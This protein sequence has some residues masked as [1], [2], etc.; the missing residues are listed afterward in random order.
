MAESLNKPLLVLV[1]LIQGLLLFGLKETVI[2]EVWPHD[3]RS[4][5]LLLWSICLC[6]PI[7]LLL[8]L[9]TD[10]F[11]QTSIGAAA[12]AAVLVLIAGYVGFQL[13]PSESIYPSSMLWIYGVTLAVLLFKV[14]MYLQ[15]WAD[16]QPLTYAQ[17]FLYSWRNTILVALCLLFVLI[18]GGILT[19]WA[20]LFSVVGINLFREI[21]SESWFL[22]PV[23]ALANGLAFVIFRNLVGILD[24]MSRVLRALCQFLLPVLIFICLLFLICLPFVGISALW[25]TGRGTALVLWLQALILFFYNAT[26]QNEM[27]A[28]PYW[29]PIQ[30][31]ISLGLLVL[32]IYSLIAIYGLWLRVDQYGLTV[33]RCWAMV[34]TILLALF[35][36]AYTINLLWFR[37]NAS[38]KF[39]WINVRMGLVVMALMVLVNTPFLDFRK[40]TVRSQLATLE[41]GEVSLEEFDVRY[42]ARELG[43]PGYL[44][45]EQL[46]LEQ[47]EAFSGRVAEAYRRW[48]A[49]SVTLSEEQAIEKIRRYPEELEIPEALLAEVTPLASNA[50]NSAVYVLNP[51]LNGD[52]TGD[53]VVITQATWNYVNAQHWQIVEGRW[54]RKNLTNSISRPNTLNLAEAFENN[55]VSVEA[56]TWQLLKIGDTVFQISE[57]QPLANP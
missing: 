24:T 21:F 37:A 15:I 28:S 34:V 56:P 45:L 11:K 31:F 47:D 3:V 23:L 22:F 29:K 17:L 57:E 41:S 27:E 32:P 36:I 52:G 5:E 49:E 4:A 2:Y 7:L 55:E 19:L 1:A 9:N 26:Y 40:A 33:A 8:S 54:E 46:K 38:D 53:W 44:A 50:N 12:F 6:V 14:T 20:G 18:F 30:R 39:G 51:D 43:R 10:N 25:D 35:A 13:E 16:K 42:F 48:N